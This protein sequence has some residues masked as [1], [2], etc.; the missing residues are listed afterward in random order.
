MTKPTEIAADANPL[1]PLRLACVPGL[2]VFGVLQMEQV[3]E[4][5]HF[6]GSAGSPFGLCDCTRTV[7]S[8][9]IEPEGAA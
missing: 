4:G 2:A 5:P 1:G 9:G 3:L 7:E 8:S 6:E